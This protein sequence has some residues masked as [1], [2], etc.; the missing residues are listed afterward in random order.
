MESR[1]SGEILVNAAGKPVDR[2][3]EYVPL[4]NSRA[5]SL[6]TIWCC[7][8]VPRAKV[9]RGCDGGTARRGGGADP[10][11]GDIIAL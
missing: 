3:G 1:D 6:A 5:R 4:L 2:Q 8:D 11:T 7:M 9:A 10:K